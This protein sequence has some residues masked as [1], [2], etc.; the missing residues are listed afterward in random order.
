VGHIFQ[1]GKKYTQSMRASVLAEDG[2]PVDLLM[3]AYGIGV[4]RI[5][6]AAIEQH[7]DVQ[8]ICWPQAMAPF[9]W[10]LI[11]LNG[12]KSP[13]VQQTAETLY[14]Q[15]QQQG[16]EV[17]LED[18]LERPGVKFSDMDLIGIPHR[19]VISERSLAA[20]K[21]EYKNR[22]ETASQDLLLNDQLLIKLKQLA[23]QPA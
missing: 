5:V 10:V 11:P 4:S 13:K 14:Q 22:R 20:G 17:L 21:V 16:Y 23:D 1:Q 7:H 6:A 9:Q 18:R 15:L 12:H 8:G 2:K 3:C 19:L